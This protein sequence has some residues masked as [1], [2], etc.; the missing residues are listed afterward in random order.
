MATHNGRVKRPLIAATLMAVLIVVVLAV[1]VPGRLMVAN[2]DGPPASVDVIG[3]GQVSAECNS[4]TQTL[5]IPLFRLVPRDVV[6]TDTRSGA[7]L[8]RLRLSGDVV[9]LIRRDGVIYGPPGS[10][11]GPAPVNGCA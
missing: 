10:S 5:W 2:I 11:Y 3:V 6:V 7:V 1:V 9:V 4:G 8:R